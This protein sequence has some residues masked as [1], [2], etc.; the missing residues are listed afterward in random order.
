MVVTGLLQ[1][2]ASQRCMAKIME[3]AG[4]WLMPGLPA[5][6]ANTG[7]M[8][9]LRLGL[10]ELRREKPRAEDWVYIL[11]HTIQIGKTKALL[12][13]GVQLSQWE[14]RGRGSLRHQDLS[15]LDLMPMEHSSGEIVAARLRAATE[16]TGIPLQILSDGGTDL[17]KGITI[18]QESHRSVKRTLDVTHKMALLLRARLE[19][20]PRWT[21]FTQSLGQTRSQVLLTGLAC[22]CPPSLKTKARYM[23]L[24][25]IVRWGCR[26]LRRLDQPGCLAQHSIDHHKL[27]EKLGWLS[28]YREALY[29][30]SV[31]LKIAK[32]TE[33]QVRA[34]G[35]HAGSAGQ[36]QSRLD[37]LAINESAHVMQSAVI[38]F[39]A[40]QAAQAI[41]EQHLLGSSEVLESLIGRYK[42]LQGAH[43]QGGITSLL[44]ATGAI[45]QQSTKKT[46]MEGLSCI[47]VRDV[48]DWCG[49]H[50]GLTLQAQ[51]RRVFQEQN[52]AITLP[53]HFQ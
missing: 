12:I 6:C 14:K 47:R 11:D 32:T 27:R 24:A 28:E 44:L 38:E 19:S 37:G 36:L 10:H 51:R 45:V 26:T 13:V 3:L 30:W 15:L 5:P 52:Q 23:N 4:K 31:L 46:I 16:R 20:D 43:S 9:L 21:K 39:V 7:R 29:H 42:H 17:A 8:W 48:L 2:A 53:S 34:D 22:F 49:T 25:P 35:Y 41:P 33:R 1:A 50:L 18:F 40:E